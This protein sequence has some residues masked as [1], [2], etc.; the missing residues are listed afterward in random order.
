MPSRIIDEPFTRTTPPLTER[1]T[2]FW[3]SGKDGTLRILWCESCRI[4]V[5][6]PGPV[7]PGCGTRDIEPRAVS[8]R[9]V[10]YSFTINEYRWMPELEPPY[11]VAEVD[12][13]EQ[14]GLRL[15]TNIVEC[16]VNDV[17]VAMVVEVV[18]AKHGDA[19]VP[20]FTPVGAK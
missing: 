2:S 9:G 1:N 5:H 18:F 20:L 7:C 15:M 14:E 3:T 6:P 19:Y 13:V 16:D 11:V 4:Y 8:G 10:I 12:L 17:R